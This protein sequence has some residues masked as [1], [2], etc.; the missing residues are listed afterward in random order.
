MTALVAVQNIAASNKRQQPTARATTPDSTSDKALKFR[1]QWRPA[2][3]GKRNRLAA[4]WKAMTLLLLN[5][6]APMDT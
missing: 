2:D 4:K 3:D 1:T 6:D 5:L